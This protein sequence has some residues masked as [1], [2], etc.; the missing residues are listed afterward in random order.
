MQIEVQAENTGGPDSNVYGVLCRVDQEASSYYFLVI[1]SDGYYG[2]GKVKAQEQKL[3]SS[4]TMLP[5][6]A[7]R[8]GRGVNHIRADCVGDRLVLYANGQKLGE[9]RDNEFVEGDI[10]LTAGT[11]EQPGVDIH[12]TDL[13]VLQPDR[14]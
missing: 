13:R 12:F 11:F 1:S 10:G 4:P 3:L 9:T 7:I 14:E 2:I 5:H 8:Q 6:P